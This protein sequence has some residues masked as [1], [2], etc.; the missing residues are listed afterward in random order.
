M[1]QQAVQPDR[2]RKRALRVNG[3]VR[4]HVKK[5]TAI[6]VSGSCGVLSAFAVPAALVVLSKTVIMPSLWSALFGAYLGVAGVIEPAVWWLLPWPQ[7]VPG[8]GAPGAFA[9]TTAC[10]LLVWGSLF[11]VGWFFIWRGP[12]RQS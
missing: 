8:G 3:G 12:R 10:I 11:S 9:I 7:L 4:G 6:V 1:A 5:A 2:A